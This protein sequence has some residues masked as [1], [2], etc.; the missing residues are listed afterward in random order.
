MD[1][2]IGSLDE[3]LT[4]VKDSYDACITHLDHDLS[5]DGVEATVR[6]HYLKF[7]GNRQPKLEALAEA[8]VHHIIYFCSSSGQRFE[9]LSPFEC[10]RLFTKAR[11]L[12]RSVEKSGE[13]GEL[14]L[15]FLLESVTM[16]PQVVSKI[17]LKTNAN[18][19]VKGGDGIHVRFDEE[20]DLLNVYLGEAKLYQGYG[21]ALQSAIESIK[22]LQDPGRV[23]H[24]LNLVTSH[25]KWLNSDLKEAVCLYLDRQNPVGSYRIVHACLV[26]FDWSEYKKLNG[27]DRGKFVD[28][29]TTLYGKQGR[30]LV[31]KAKKLIES[32]NLTNLTFEFFFLPFERVETFREAFQR[33]LRGLSKDDG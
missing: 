22:G 3:Y 26:G 23:E 19:E 31:G 28:E 15:Y 21:K 12:F 20:A 32:A 18:D 16:A 17:S 9:G 4:A 29:F 10:S 7:D 30:K 14:L 24:E 27:P 5:I 2:P 11:D 8:L 6:L 1:R 33:I 13:P 25:F